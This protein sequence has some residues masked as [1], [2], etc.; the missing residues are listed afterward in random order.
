MCEWFGCVVV[1]RLADGR[2]ELRY[3]GIASHRIA[4]HH[5]A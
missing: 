3:D 4:S 2:Y 5:M 1:E